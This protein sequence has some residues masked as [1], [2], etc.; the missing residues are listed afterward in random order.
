MVRSKDP[1]LLQVRVS[2]EATRLSPQHLIDAYDR[3][4]PTIRRARLRSN[5]DGLPVAPMKTAKAGGEP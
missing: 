3:L 2:F 1:S 5:R 4:M